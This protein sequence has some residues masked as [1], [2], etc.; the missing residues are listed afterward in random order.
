MTTQA[1]QLTHTDT[2][3]AHATA[4]L[5]LSLGV[6]TLAHG[7]LKVFVFTVP[8]TVGY[9]ESL[10]L[11]GFIAYLTIFAE[12]GGGLA[13]LFGVYTRWVSLALIP[14]LLGA[15]WVHL[16][17][18]W[19]FSNEG[20]GWEFPVFWAIALLVQAGLGSGSLTLSRRFA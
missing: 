20:G 11:P 17:N 15:A 4:L 2:L 16:G 6:M 12:I 9:F 18:G 5:R 19:V 1:I 10:G 14:I 13:L 8:G 3:Q 7:L